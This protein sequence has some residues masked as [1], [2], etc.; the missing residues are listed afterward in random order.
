MSNTPAVDAAFWRGRRVFLTGHTGFKG[1]WL[2]LWLSEMGAEVFGFSLDAPTA[3]NLFGLARVASRIT[4]CHGDI[5]DGAALFAAMDQFKPQVVIHMAAQ[6][7]VRPSYATPV[8]TYATNVMGTVHLLEAV[9]RLASVQ[10]TLIVTSDK[11]YENREVIWGYR[12]HDAMGGHDPY[13]NSKG[14]AELV[15]AAYGHSFFAVSAALGALASGRAGNVI[16]GGDWAV[17]RLLPDVFR[18]LLDGRAPV[19]RRPGAIRPWQHV[20]E[21]LSG[22][23]KAVEHITVAG[24]PQAAQS[25]NFGPDA[26]AEQPVRHV[27]ETVCTLWGGGIAPDIQ[28]DPNAPHEA[29]LLTLDATKARVELGWRPRWT[30]HQALQH[31]VDWYRAFA[32]GDDLERCCLAQIAAYQNQTP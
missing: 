18:A 28:E 19:I 29:R 26:S 8:E 23:L 9:R 17:D 30:L 6:A 22:Y 32:Q 5:R 20:L 24:G 11:C 27:A 2:S 3:P 14:C 31:T 25:W 15:T 4:H 13:S 12:E 7:L 16:G 21:P 1:A 10:A